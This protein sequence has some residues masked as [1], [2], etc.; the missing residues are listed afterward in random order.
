MRSR[1]YFVLL[2]A[3]TVI[4]GLASLIARP[5]APKIVTIWWLP[6]LLAVALMNALVFVVVTN[7]RRKDPRKFASSYL[8]ATM[9][10][11]LVIV[12]ALFVFAVNNAAQAKPFLITFLIYY[13]IYTVFETVAL[14][15]RDKQS[16]KHQ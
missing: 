15:R 10:R 11:M 8:G 14:V 9:G 12:I 13:V 16:L 1:R 7:A 6:M 4:V 3:L 2:A 5:Y